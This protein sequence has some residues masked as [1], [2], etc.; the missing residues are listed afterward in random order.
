MCINSLNFTDVQLDH[1]I[2]YEEGEVLSVSGSD[3]AS[4]EPRPYEVP[5]SSTTDL[6]NEAAY[7]PQR[8]VYSVYE[9]A[10]QGP[11]EEMVQILIH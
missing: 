4:R 2:Y 6:N 8:S 3:D 7:D 1:V 10:T 5:V 9:Y 11:Y